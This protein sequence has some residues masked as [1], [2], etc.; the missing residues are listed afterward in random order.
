MQDYDLTAVLITSA[1]L[2]FF[3]TIIEPN[4][5]IPFVA[6]AKSNSWSLSKAEAATLACGSGHMVSSLIFGIVGVALGAALGGIE[7]VNEVRTSAVRWMLLAF[8]T[9]YLICGIKTALRSKKGGDHCGCLNHNHERKLLS[10]PDFWAMFAI[11]LLG[12]CEILI[13][14]VIYPASNSDWAGVIWVALT[15][16]LAS[17]A[18]MAIAVAALFKG[19]NRIKNIPSS[20]TRWGHALTGATIMLCAASMFAFGG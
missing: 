13:P 19:I 17:V 1:W 5:Y 3:H 4:H 6:L 15:F 16:S 8:G 20:I 11:F 12:P 9:A 7:S 14:L 2:G 18:T 10:S